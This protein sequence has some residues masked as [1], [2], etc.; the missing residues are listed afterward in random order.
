MRSAVLVKCTCM[1]FLSISL[2]SCAS[3]STPAAKSEPAFEPPADVQNMTGGLF[4]GE[5]RA[6][7]ASVGESSQGQ[8]SEE[9]SVDSR[10]ITYALSLDL[11]VK[12]VEEAK[13][14]LLG[15][16]KDKNG[17]IVRETDRSITA[18]IPAESMDGFVTYARTLGKVE[19]E[20]R[21][22]TDITDR[23]RDNVTRLNSLIR[24]RDR[25]LALI[26]QADAVADI[27]RI[28]R[29][30]ERISTE[31]EVL[32]GRIKHAEQSVVF[33]SITVSFREKAKLGP[34]G[35]VFYGLYRGIGVLFVWDW[36]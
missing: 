8:Q 9:A 24:V 3:N 29:E 11:V 34:I 12:S 17:F 5:V 25:Y 30:L 35:W 16:I 6:Q 1:I 20:S 22:G 26:E 13:Q 21:T 31:I 7:R 28:E 18:R 10:M 36:D 33:S 4:G 27:L 15:Q 14:G 2:F 23:Y 19:D 32:Q